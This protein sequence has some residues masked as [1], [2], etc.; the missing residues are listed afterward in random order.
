M[1]SCSSLSAR[2]TCFTRMELLF[3]E[4]RLLR[5]YSISQLPPLPLG[6]HARSLVRAGTLVAMELNETKWVVFQEAEQRKS[7]VKGPGL[8]VRHLQGFIFPTEVPVRFWGSWASA[9]G[10]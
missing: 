6:D 8:N 5:P 2:I 4:S 7:R 10:C 9:R 3:Q 1:K